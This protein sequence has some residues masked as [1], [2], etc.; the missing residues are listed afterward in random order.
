MHALKSGDSGFAGFGEA[1][2]SIVN[3][4]EIKGWKKHNLMTLNILVPVGEI[5][6]V[7]Y[8]GYDFFNIKL[9]KKNYNR[10]TI[11]PKLWVAFKGLANFNMLINLASHQHDPNE[12]ENLPLDDI[13]YNW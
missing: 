6:F 9:S 3:V 5:E 1:Y 10:L 13:N 7:I 4:N 2:F 8:N 11:E 12:A